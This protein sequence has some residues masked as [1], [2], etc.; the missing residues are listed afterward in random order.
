MIVMKHE[1]IFR[2][3]SPIC[4]FQGCYFS[5]AY[6][7]SLSLPLCQGPYSSS[8]KKCILSMSKNVQCLHF[9]NDFIGMNAIT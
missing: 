9:Q 4:C 3:L 5:I 8:Q 6:A 2:E 1:G 7:P